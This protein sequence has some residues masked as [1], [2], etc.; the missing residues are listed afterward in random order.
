MRR[1]PDASSLLPKSIPFPAPSPLRS[2][3]A[4]PVSIDSVWASLLLKHE[5]ARNTRAVET[6]AA[7]NRW[8][9]PSKEAEFLFIIFPLVPTP[10]G[11]LGP[12]DQS[13]ARSTPAEFSTVPTAPTS[14]TIIQPRPCSFCPEYLLLIHCSESGGTRQILCIILHSILN[15]R[16]AVSG[17]KA[18]LFPPFGK[19]RQ[20]HKTFE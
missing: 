11:K 5:S 2:R 19:P 16:L 3:I 17:S 20:C 4:S 14:A 18:F 12:M 8:K 6:A 13:A 10:L 9:N 7:W 1:K 15:S